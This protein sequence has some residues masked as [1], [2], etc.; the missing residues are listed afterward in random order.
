MSC[1]IEGCYLGKMGGVGSFVIL[2]PAI[3]A[4]ATISVK[5]KKPSMSWVSIAHPKTAK[6]MMA[7]SGVKSFMNSGTAFSPLWWFINDSEFRPPAFFLFSS[8]EAN[9]QLFSA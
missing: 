4:I 5:I 3:P 6:A 2:Y 8:V 9:L 1:G 7:T